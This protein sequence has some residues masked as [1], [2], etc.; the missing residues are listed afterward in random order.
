MEH[1]DIG[2]LWQGLL[3][4]EEALFLQLYKVWYPGLLTYGLRITE[5]RELVK[6]AINQ[7]FLYFW[8][9]RAVL[10]GVEQPAAYMYTAFRRRLITAANN[11][12]GKIFLPG[13]LV[14]EGLDSIEESHETVLIHHVN[15]A[16]IQRII[17]R[18]I[19]QLSG[20]KQ[21][22]IRMK[23][24]EGLSYRQIANKTKLTERT[25]YNKIHE[26]IKTLRA[27]LAAD[28]HSGDMIA[29]IQLL[30]LL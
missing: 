18:A 10:T 2:E 7:T 25:I 8:Q 17:D 4:G 21:E 26:A 13:D 9:K 28:G 30:L 20:R 16:N 12:N 19:G 15:V 3:K 5:D 11:S 14:E 27:N 23:Y 24:Y 1:T 29:T 22:L 6:D